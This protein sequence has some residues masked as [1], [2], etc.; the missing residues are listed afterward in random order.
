MTFQNET[1][2]SRSEILK[3]LD[4]KK[5]YEIFKARVEK[6]INQIDA[7]D[8]SILNCKSCK[9]LVEKFKNNTSIHY[10]KN[11]NIL[12]MG[13]APANNGW[14]KSGKSWHDPSGKKLA[15]GKIMDKLLKEYNLLIE[16]ITFVEAIKCFPVSRNSIKK[17][18]KECENILFKQ[19]KILNPKLIIT[20]GD[21]ATKSILKEPTYKKFSEVVGNIY[22][23]FVEGR[24]YDVLPIYHPSPISPKSYTGNIDIIKKIENYI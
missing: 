10:G 7:I 9:G 23:I 11:L 4:T 1:T 3:C 5:R 22:S 21:A 6:F 8:K 13:E 18:A 24:D 19:L 15:S 12:I 16:D 14:R 2:K 20:L 17:C